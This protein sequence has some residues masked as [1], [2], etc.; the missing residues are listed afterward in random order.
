MFHFSNGSISSKGRRLGHVG[1]GGASP[2]HLGSHAAKNSLS[3]SHQQ[4]KRRRRQRKA[5]AAAAAEKNKDS[6]ITE[7]A[8]RAASSRHKESNI[9]NNEMISSQNGTKLNGGKT[10]NNG[11]IKGTCHAGENPNEDDCN[12]GDISA[13]LLASLVASPAKNMSSKQSSH[14]C[15]STTNLAERDSPQK[16]PFKTQIFSQPRQNKNKSFSSS[17][18]MLFGM[19]SADHD[20]KGTDGRNNMNKIGH[21]VHGSSATAS[22]V[23][24]S[25]QDRLYNE[26]EMTQQQMQA[27]YNLS[28]VPPL[29]NSPELQLR[30]LNPPD[31]PEVKRLCR[32]WFPIEY[33]DAWYSDITSNH[34]FYSVCAVYRGQIIG[35]IVAEIKE[36][37]NLPKEDS[38][39]LAPDGVCPPLFGGGNHGRKSDQQIGYILSL[40]VVKEFRKNGIASFLLDNL[41]AHLTN[42]YNDPP[43]DGVRA[44]YLH[45][46]TTNS[47]AISFYEHRGFRAHLFLPYYYAIKGRRRD[48]FTY[49]L[50]LNGGHPPWSLL[51]YA[52]HCLQATIYGIITLQPVRRWLNF[53]IFLTRSLLRKLTGAAYAAAAGGGGG[54]QRLAAGGAGVGY[55]ING[56]NGGQGV[57]PRIRQ[58]AHSS[59]AAVFTS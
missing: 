43:T 27:A 25:A 14:H 32:E 22:D 42:P 19:P 23:A 30:F 24:L 38:E 3:G 44:L 54:N 47:Q 5:A 39:I 37:A 9:K 28:R 17:S 35:L 1:I 20:Y 45:V 59:T 8:K 58:I 49:V 4:R 33:P 57:W 56:G 46:L 15:Q 2:H 7:D 53:P 50:Y 52:G 10:A 34:K 21:H 55:A 6:V 31:I 11:E 48:G 16:T 51:D 29:I 13:S 26:N 36:T 41:V 40:G 18:E 12:F